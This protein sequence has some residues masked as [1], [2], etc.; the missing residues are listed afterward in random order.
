MVWD[1]LMAGKRGDCQITTEDEAS[2]RKDIEI[3]RGQGWTDTEIYRLLRSTE[4]FDNVTAENVASEAVTFDTGAVLSLTRHL[5]LTGAASRG[6]RAAN[7][8]DLGSVGLTGGGG[9]EIA[10]STAASLGALVGSTAASGAVSTG[11]AVPALAPEVAYTY[12]AGVKFQSG[13]VSASEIGRISTFAV[14]SGTAGTAATGSFP[15][16]SR[17]PCRPSTRSSSP[18]SCSAARR[19][20]GACGAS[21]RPSP[22]R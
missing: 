7:A 2:L 4:Y 8:A 14:E 20:S 13:R 17:A 15:R 18:T 22:R 6:F 9:F 3:W 5:R 19:R 11:R 16:G 1:R 10:P 12:E 21:G